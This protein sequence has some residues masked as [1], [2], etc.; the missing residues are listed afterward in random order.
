[1]TESSQGK[2][3]I[4]RTYADLTSE[5][6]MMISEAKFK[7]IQDIAFD[8]GKKMNAYWLQQLINQLKLQLWHKEGK[9]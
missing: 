7:V 4:V 6:I 9:I 2:E 8:F 5:Q 3:K 1:M